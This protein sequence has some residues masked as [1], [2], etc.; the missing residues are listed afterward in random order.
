MPE[1]KQRKKQARRP[2]VPAPEKKK[3]KP[4]PRWYGFLILGVMLI[5]VFSIVLNY[6]GI[7]PGGTNPLW[8]WVG[9][10]LIAA[11]FGGATRWR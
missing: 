5:G 8:L 3:P 6:M 2:Y 10:G 7:M 11:G 1:S 9:L 4:S